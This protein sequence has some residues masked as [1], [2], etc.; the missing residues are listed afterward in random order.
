MM[1]LVACPRVVL[2]L[3]QAITDLRGGVRA[4]QQYQEQAQP[5]VQQQQQ[6]PQQYASYDAGG[7]G[8]VGSPAAGG[9][10][11][12]VGSWG[13]DDDAMPTQ[14][15]YGQQQ[16]YQQQQQQQQQMQMQQGQAAA[17]AA[18]PGNAT[19]PPPTLNFRSD[20]AFMTANELENRQRAQRELQRDLDQQIQEK[21]RRKVGC[22][23]CSVC[24]RG[25][26]CEVLCC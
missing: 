7:P 9:A 26:R 5:H 2:L 16:Q 6:M 10:A 17:A 25:K 13:A 21:K 1:Y 11:G 12:Y 24:M 4:E 20:K 19:G 8:A 15:G 22:T 14:N 18:G 23:A 3:L